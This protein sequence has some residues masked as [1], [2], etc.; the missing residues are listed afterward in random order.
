LLG[1]T[2]TAII[3]APQGNISWLRPC[4]WW[5]FQKFVVV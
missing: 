1:K 3:F 2:A 5:F 4:V